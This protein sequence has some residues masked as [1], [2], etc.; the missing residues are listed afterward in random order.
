MFLVNYQPEN[1][2]KKLKRTINKSLIIIKIL[3]N[4]GKQCV[5]NRILVKKKINK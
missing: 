4:V 2:I 3:T 1:K 5:K